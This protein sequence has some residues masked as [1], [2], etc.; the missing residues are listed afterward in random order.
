MSRAVLL[1]R[2][3]T[4]AAVGCLPNTPEAITIAAAAATWG[5]AIEVPT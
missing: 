2:F 4:A 5:V 1:R 3:S